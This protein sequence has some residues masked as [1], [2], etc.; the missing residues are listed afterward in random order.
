[1]TTR[2]PGRP[3]ARGAAQAERRDG[4]SVV[5]AVALVVA[6]VALGVYLVQL[7]PPGSA[8][9]SSASGRSPSETS[10][11]GTGTSSGS[12]TTT[13]TPTTSPTTTTTTTA[14]GAGATKTVKVLVANASQTNGIAAYYTNQLAS[15]GWGTLPPV[16]ALTAKTT[17]AVYFATGDQRFAQAV[18]SELGVASTSVAALGA[19]TPVQGTTAAQVVVVAGND[20]AAKAHPAG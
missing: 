5:K 6:A 8:G 2:E 14:A 17:S 4:R 7:R 15:A 12:S 10:P 16:T 20:L 19:S 11:S 1:M 3:A 9:G 18:A 13:S